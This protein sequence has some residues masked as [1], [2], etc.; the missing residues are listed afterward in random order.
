M[1][2]PAEKYVCVGNELHVCDD[3]AIGPIKYQCASCWNGGCEFQPC[4]GAAERLYVLSGGALRSYDP[5]LT[6]GAFGTPHELNCNIGAPFSMTIDRLGRAWVV[7]SD[8]FGARLAHVDPDHGYCE[9]IS[10]DLAESGFARFTLSFVSSVEDPASERIV[11]VGGSYAAFASKDT[12]AA[13][14]DPKTLAITQ[15]APLVGAPDITG[16][17]DGRLFGYFPFTSPPHVAQI[18]PVTAQPIM[19]WPLPAVEGTTRAWAAAYWKGRVIAFDSRSSSSLGP[20][21]NRI[22][23]VDVTSGEISTLDDDSPNTVIGAGV[24]T[25]FQVIL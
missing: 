21:R 18:D 22:F 13:Y 11:V 5:D 20:L 7:L 4:T 1:C 3:G 19:T 9:V 14:M 8:G 10:N 24:S 23:A 6:S 17:N 15:L 2:D 16:T 25:C 12:R